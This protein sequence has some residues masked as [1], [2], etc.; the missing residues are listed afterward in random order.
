MS[1]T[2][3]VTPS[4]YF[5]KSLRSRALYWHLARRTFQRYSTYRGA[6]FAGAATNTVFAFLLVSVRLALYRHRS[7]VGTFD[8]RDTVTFTFVSQ[9]FLATSGAFGYLELSDRIRTGDVVADLY[10]P[11]HF[12]SYWLA[13]EF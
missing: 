9:G 5:G 3:S 6:T 13:Q 11:V 7:T 10:R 1:G 12:L 4:T 2:F 8:V